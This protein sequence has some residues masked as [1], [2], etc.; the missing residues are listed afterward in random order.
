MSEPR[1]SAPVALGDFRVGQI[2]SRA[3][4]LFTTNFWKLFFVTAISA[5]PLLPRAEREPAGLLSV[6]RVLSHRPREL[7]QR[8][9]GLLDGG[10]LHR[11]R[12]VHVDSGR[13]DDLAGHGIVGRL[14]AVDR[15]GGVGDLNVAGGG[16]EIAGS[17]EA[18][19]GNID[20]RIGEATQGTNGRLGLVE[21]RQRLEQMDTRHLLTRRSR[22]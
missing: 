17:A 19:G 13:D 11:E 7:L 22:R 12:E 18:V 5:L 2:F 16:G 4:R 8:G 10:D 9:R 21:R 15:G 14:V 20:G 6:G 1:P 3:W